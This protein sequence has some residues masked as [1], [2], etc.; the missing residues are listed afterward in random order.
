M[1]IKED[2][3][4]AIIIQFTSHSY[5]IKYD[6]KIRIMEYSKMEKFQMSPYF[7]ASTQSHNGTEEGTHKPSEP[8]AETTKKEP[9]KLEPQS[10]N[11]KADDSNVALNLCSDGS[12]INISSNGTTLTATKTSLNAT[13]GAFTISI[14]ALTLMTGDAP[15]PPIEPSLI[16]VYTAHGFPLHISLEDSPCVKATHSL[17]KLKY[18]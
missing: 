6:L 14:N 8:I 7:T 11:G 13:I 2:D 9:S 3:S 18:Y 4:G 12:K 17:S 15:R 5:H 16:A 10:N 1:G